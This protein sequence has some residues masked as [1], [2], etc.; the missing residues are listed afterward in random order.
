MGA[1]LRSSHG[2]VEGQVERRWPGPG[3][4]A[5]RV[6]LEYPSH[7]GTDNLLMAAVAG[8]G[9]DGDRERRPASPR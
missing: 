9:H 6:V 3:W 7:T 2:Y 5:T 4:S 1:T 8:Q